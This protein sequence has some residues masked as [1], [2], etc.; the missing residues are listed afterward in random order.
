MGKILRILS[1]SIYQIQPK[2][3]HYE[4]LEV[5]QF[6][7][8]VGNEQWLYAY[9]RET[10]EVVAYVWIKR[11]LAKVQQL[12]AKLKNLGIEYIRITSDLWDSFVT[13]FKN[14]KQSIGKFFT[15]GVEGNHCRIRCGFRKS[16]NFR[17]SQ[18]TTLRLSI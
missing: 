6:W 13:F 4:C 9:Y 18:K 3:S 14:H 17:K 5:D 8:F 1:Q 11:G 16:Y 10:G 2:Q 7:I 12:K 15:V